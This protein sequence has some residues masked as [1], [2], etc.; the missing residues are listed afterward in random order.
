M[1]RVLK[2]TLCILAATAAALA[3]IPE[4]SAKKAQ[5]DNIL[6]LLS[7]MNN[8]DFKK[9]TQ[10]DSNDNLTYEYKDIRQKILRISD[11][12]ELAKLIVLAHYIIYPADADTW[13]A[14]RNFSYV[15][16]ISDM[17]RLKSHPDF[18]D[19]ML[20]IKSAIRLDAHSGEEFDEVIEAARDVP[21]IDKY[22]P[23]KKAEQPIC[24]VVLKREPPPRKRQNTSP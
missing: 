5:T 3:D 16:G 11:P 1:G 12:I 19:A 17:K 7:E 2:I 10:R 14:D 21:K 6:K 8:V 9:S 4:S 20:F 15:V 13:I 24:A 18:A 22:F 23:K